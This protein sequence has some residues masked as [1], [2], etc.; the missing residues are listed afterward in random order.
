MKVLMTL[1]LLSSFA[2]AGDHFHMP[3]EL[4][5]EESRSWYQSM[6]KTTNKDGIADMKEPFVQ[7]SIN[8][9]EKMNKWMAQIN[10]N[11]DENNQIRLTSKGTRRGIPIKSL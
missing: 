9:G 11:R 6:N 10:K 4:S 3:L 7:E 2:F 1:T 8:G 5:F